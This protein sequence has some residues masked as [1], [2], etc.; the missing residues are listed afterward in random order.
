VDRL[1]VLEPGHPDLEN[2]RDANGKLYFY[3]LGCSRHPSYSVNGALVHNS[4]I[5]KAISGKTRQKLIKLCADIPYRLCCSATPAPNDYTELGNHAEFLGICTTAEMLAQF[6]INANRQQTYVIDGRVYE[7]KGSNKGGQEWRLKHHAESRFFEWLASWAITMTKPSDLGYDDDG[8]ILPPLTITPTFVYADYQPDDQLF[9]TALKGVADRA[10][11]RRSTINARIE[12]LKEIVNCPITGD[13][14]SRE[15]R[16]REQLQSGVLQEE[17]SELSR[18]Q[19]VI[20]CELDDE[21][22]AIEHLLGDDCASIYGS[23]PLEEKER[24]LDQWLT[25]AARF[26]VSKPRVCGFGLNLQQAHH[27]AF[28][29]LSDSWETFYQCIRRQWRYRQPEPVDVHLILSDAEGAIYQNVMRKDAMATRLRQKLVEAVREYERNELGMAAP[30]EQPYQE[31]EASGHGWRLLLG[32]SC[33]RLREIEDESIDL[34][35]YSPPFAD[36]FTYSASDRDLGNCRG[37]DQFFDHYAFVIR[38]VLRVT[39]PGRLTCVHTSDIPAMQNR[40]GYIGIRDFPGAVIR[41]YEQEGWIL[42][43]RAFCQ[44]N[45]Q[46]QA[47]RTHSKGLLFVQIRKDSSDSRPCLVD[48]ILLFK[49]SGVAAVPVTPVANGEMDNETWIE[50]ANGIWLGISESDT[51]QVAVARAPEDEKHIAP[52]Q[53]GTIERCIKLYSNPGELVLSPFAGIGS[54]GHEAVRFGRRFIG[55]EL[56]PSYFQVAVNNLR[57]AEIKAGI[58]DMFDL[59]LSNA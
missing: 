24:R 55:I 58:R 19:W 6:F 30:I 46:Q 32:D 16:G 7:K 3:D 12:A 57:K 8:F 37:W 14:V 59:E 39:K 22:R 4:S 43:G 21:Q 44:K 20:W 42:H 47:I 2:L 23:L 49:K 54:E 40:D 29:G 18:A 28:L 41:A 50:W 27:M 17:S 5:L 13:G 26:L 15:W 9:F 36:L 38:E 52:L 10:K 31:S 56:K 33:E 11:V 45:P 51:L 35:A 34:S 53:L 25:G 1:E 48:Q